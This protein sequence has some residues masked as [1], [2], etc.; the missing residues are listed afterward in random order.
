MRISL[1]TC[2]LP[3]WACAEGAPL[4]DDEN[5]APL[6]PV[7]TEAAE[8][9][10]DPGS[11]EVTLQRSCSVIVRF[12]REDAVASELHAGCDFPFV[13]EAPTGAVYDGDILEVF[14]AAGWTVPSLGACWVE[15]ANGQRGEVV[16]NLVVE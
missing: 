9:Y 5:T 3:L 6:L 14:P 15:L 4:Q 10:I 2:I 16:V 13:I 12:D 8:V 1:F 11:V 7:T